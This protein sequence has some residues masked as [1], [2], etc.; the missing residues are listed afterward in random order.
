V[1]TILLY[2]FVAK[3]LLP[4]QDNGL[5]IGVTDAAPSISFRAMVERQREVAEI[6]GRDPDVQSVASFVGAGPVN[7]TLNSGRIYINL[8]PRARRHASASEIIARLRDATAT[9]PGI[10]FF[11]QAAQDVQID[12]RVSRTQYQ[13]TLQ[14]ADSTELSDWAARLL[15]KLGEQPQLA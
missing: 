2:V 10:S 13:F 9:V 11:M 14:D 4:Q 12:S 15:A 1:A 6:A 8:K 5:I 7:A 3:G